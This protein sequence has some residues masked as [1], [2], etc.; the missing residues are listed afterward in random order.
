MFICAYASV[1]SLGLPHYTM[2]AG[3]TLIML[4]ARVGSDKYHF[5]QFTR[6][7]FKS[8]RLE[9]LNLLKRESDAQLIRPA[10]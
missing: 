2:A 10:L 9:S 6:P 1:C 4:N 3:P 5:I 7:G 8:M